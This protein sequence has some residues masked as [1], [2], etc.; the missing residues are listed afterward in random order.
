VGRLR[1]QYVAGGRLWWV[2]YS[3][4]GYIAGGILR[5]V[6][7]GGSIAAA[8]DRLQRVDSSGSFKGVW[9]KVYK[10]LYMLTSVF[11]RVTYV[12]YL[13]TDCFSCTECKNDYQPT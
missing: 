2:N 13:F 3:R 5:G 11:L 9:K 10:P 8:V 6:Y 4:G 12:K 7:C 1:L